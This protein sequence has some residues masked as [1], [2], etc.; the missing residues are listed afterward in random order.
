MRN[1][2]GQLKNVIS[3]DSIFKFMPLM[4]ALALYASGA[5][6]Q[7]ISG[8]ITSPS[9]GD[10]VPP[11]YEVAGTISNLPSGY[12]LWVAVRRG[13]LLYPKEP[14]SF[15]AGTNWD[16]TISEGGK[17]RYRLV[18]LVVDSKGHRD[19]KDWLRV[20]NET[21]HFPG[22]ESIP[23]CKAIHAISVIAR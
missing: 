13:N 20:G 10:Q 8:Q 22:K 3:Y 11:R 23:G 21:S 19:I 12:H 5:Y 6:A 15:V 4:I 1:R 7:E 2:L 9:N 14:E 17:G 18:L 16:T